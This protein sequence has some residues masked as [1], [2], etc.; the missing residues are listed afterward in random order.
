M[1]TSK[2]VPLNTLAAGTDASISSIS[3]G[4]G[5][6]HRLIGMGLKIGSRVTVMHSSN[7][8][9]GPTLVAVGDT[10]LAIGHGMAERIM[11]EAD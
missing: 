6:H 11:V 5:M 2:L 10:R 4:R 3:G 9:G 7:G 1:S 8:R